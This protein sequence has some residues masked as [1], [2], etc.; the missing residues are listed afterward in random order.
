MVYADRQFNYSGKIPTESNFWD[1]P[2]DRFV[3]GDSLITKFSR[4]IGEQF[5]M[6]IKTP[7]LPMYNRFAGASLRAG[8]GLTERMVCKN[9][10]KHYNPKASASDALSFYDTAGI[11]KNYTENIAGWRPITIPSDLATFDEFVNGSDIEKLNSYIYD[12][13][14]MGY[15]RDVESIIE[16]YVSS[17]IKNDDTLDYDPSDYPSLIIGLSEIANSMMGEK[18]AYNELTDDEN[19]T[20]YHGADTGIYAFIDK[21]LYDK[22]M[23]SKAYLTNPDRIIENV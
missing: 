13:N 15:Q 9:P 12:N 6:P 7:T 23:S 8:A 11:E 4:V 20:I 16:K 2:I 21:S 17:T 22:I 5:F 18:T 19:L 14:V 10:S 3:S 1:Q